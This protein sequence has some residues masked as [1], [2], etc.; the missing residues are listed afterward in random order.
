MGFNYDEGIKA[1]NN[2]TKKEKKTFLYELQIELIKFP[3]MYDIYP[4]DLERFDGIV[5][6]CYL[7]VD[8]LTK[9]ELFRSLE[10]VRRAMVFLSLFATDKL[11]LDMETPESFDK[12][13]GVG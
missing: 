13:A 3:L 1:Y 2:L 5:F 4:L 7:W 11:H 6:E 8:D 9:T 10:I 12:K